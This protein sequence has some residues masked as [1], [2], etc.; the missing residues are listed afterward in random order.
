MSRLID[1]RKFYFGNFYITK[2]TIKK[3]AF[4]AGLIP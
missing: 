2:N 1:L 4:I 3:D